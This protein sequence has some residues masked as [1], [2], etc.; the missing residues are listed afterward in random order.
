MRSTGSPG[1][2][3]VMHGRRHPFLPS[4]QHLHHE[5]GVAARLLVERCRRLWLPAAQA[6]YTLRREGAEG[7]APHGR[8]GRQVTQKQAERMLGRQLV[9]TEGEQQRLG[10]AVERRGGTARH[11]DVAEPGTLELCLLEADG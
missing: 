8:R 11:G 10:A 5:K 2:H 9:I 7:D 1:Q 3:C 6:L 4:R